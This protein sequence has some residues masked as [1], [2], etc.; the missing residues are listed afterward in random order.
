MLDKKKKI[1]A[2]NQ[3]NVVRNWVGL[4]VCGGGGGGVDYIKHT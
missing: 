1:Q 4:E 2:T 3:A